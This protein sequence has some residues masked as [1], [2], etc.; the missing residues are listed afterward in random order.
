M[1]RIDL[2]A[3]L[4]RVRTCLP[5]IVEW[6]RYSSDPDTEISGVILAYGIIRE[7]I[8]TGK[9]ELRDEMRQAMVVTVNFLHASWVDFGLKTRKIPIWNDPVVLAAIRALGPWVS[10]NIDSQFGDQVAKVHPMFIWL[11]THGYAKPNGTENSARLDFRIA[12]L[13]AMS[14]LRAGEEDGGSSF[15]NSYGWETLDGA[16]V[17]LSWNVRRGPSSSDVREDI[18][19][20]Y[21]IIGVLSSLVGTWEGGM[22]SCNMDVFSSYC[23]WQAPD[24]QPNEESFAFQLACIRFGTSIFKYLE[25][26]SKKED[27]RTIALHIYQALGASAALPWMTVKLVETVEQ[28]MAEIADADWEGEY[29]VKTR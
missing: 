28:L 7:E 21:R 17:Q 20:G 19:L 8:V 15:M 18:E 16:L 27:Y 10:E 4:I 23:D 12:V 11:Y 25:P 5:R 24:I 26:I 1:S 29:R 3:A 14:D 2:V 6:G 13:D 22:E 9:M